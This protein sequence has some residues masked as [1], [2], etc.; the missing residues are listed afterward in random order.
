[1]FEY[2]KKLHKVYQGDVWDILCEADKEFIPPLSERNNTTLQTFSKQKANNRKPVQYYKQML[3]QEFILAI[4]GKKTIGFL[5]FIPDYLLQVN[6][7]EFKCDYIT[8][9]VVSTDFRGREI[10]REMYHALFDNRRGKNF[11]TRTWSTNY[12]HLHLL[13]RMEFKRIAFLPNDR[14][15]GIDTVY[16]FKVGIEDA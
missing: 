11:A 16:Y 8:T 3:K 12:T 7:K 15:E 14:V 13:D 10:A 9:I 4:E 2:Q 1:M 6:G 5:T